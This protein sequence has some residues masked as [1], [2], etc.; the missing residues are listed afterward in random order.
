MRVDPLT[1]N[2]LESFVTTT[3]L[4]DGAGM[5]FAPNGDLL[6]A[7]GDTGGTDN[8]YRVNFGTNTATL[9]LIGATGATGGTSNIYDHGLSGLAFAP[10]PEPTTVVALGLGALAFIRRRN[11]R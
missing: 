1:G 4:G 3:V 11:V 5:S 8:L 6:I 2:T 9:A 10:V 7:D